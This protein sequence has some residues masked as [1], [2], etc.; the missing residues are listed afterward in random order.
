MS[1]ESLMGND[2]TSGIDP[3]R[4]DNRGN[5]L[6]A[7]VEFD[8]ERR[9]DDGEF[10][11][12][13]AVALELF[14]PNQRAVVMLR[15]MEGLTTQEVDELVT[16]F[17]EGELPFWTSMRIRAHIMMCPPCRTWMRQ[18]KHTAKVTGAIPP[19]DMPQD[20]ENSMMHL[21]AHM[22][23]SQTEADEVSKTT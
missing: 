18:I 19:L 5:W 1:L 4:L 8:P 13:L 23:W 22:D 2:N 21:L 20:V 9:A 10:M 7:P 17:L 12:A 11:K 15:D 14:P 6:N 3:N 16:S